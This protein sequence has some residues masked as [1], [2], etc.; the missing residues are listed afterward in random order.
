MLRWFLVVLVVANALMWAWGRGWLG[1]TPGSAQREPERLTQQLAPERLQWLS[2]E[3]AKR[4]MRHIPVCREVGPLASPEALAGARAALAS[5]GVNE[6]QLWGQTAAGEWVVASREADDAADLG[7]KKQALAR[8][9]VEAQ[10]ERL[11]EDQRRSWVLS[12][13]ASRAEAEAA[14]TRLRDSKGL[15]ALRSVMT[16]APRS[17]TFLRSADW[18]H[19]QAKLQAPE[20]PGSPRACADGLSRLPETADSAASAPA[21]A[22]SGPGR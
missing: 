21:S 13:H 8:A 17:E 18:P 5:A 14:L 2:A 15:R 6:V 9:N 1:G 16:R 11:G 12:R 22:A 3:E 7:R 10:A 19:A 20:W 4:A